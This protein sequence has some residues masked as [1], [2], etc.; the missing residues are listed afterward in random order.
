MRSLIPASRRTGSVERISR[1]DLANESPQG[2]D[3][4]LPDRVAVGKLSGRGRSWVENASCGLSH[5][6]E[7]EIRDFDS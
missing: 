6:K 7:L 2:P 1:G 5:R 3:L 4:I